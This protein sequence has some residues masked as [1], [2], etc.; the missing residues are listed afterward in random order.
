MAESARADIA[1]AVVDDVVT[2]R[3]GQYAGRHVVQ[4]QRV[5]DLPGDDVVGARGVATDADAADEVRVGVEREPATEHVHAATD[6]YAATAPTPEA[7]AT[8]DTTA[9]NLVE[10]FLVFTVLPV[11]EVDLGLR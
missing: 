6:P 10:R 7:S 8:A 9:I 11:S 2:G 5:P 4:L 1:D 3:F